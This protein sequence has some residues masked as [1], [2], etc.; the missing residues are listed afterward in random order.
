MAPGHVV[1]A[2]QFCIRMLLEVL[3]QTLDAL[4]EGLPVFALLALR[5]ECL[6]PQVI[7]LAEQWTDSIVAVVHLFFLSE[8]HV[9]QVSVA[10]VVV[11][12]HRRSSCRRVLSRSD[13]G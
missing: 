2:T 3:A 13:V 9:D 10:G 11:A 8:G 6:Y 5:G 12:S 1:E 4:L 7:A